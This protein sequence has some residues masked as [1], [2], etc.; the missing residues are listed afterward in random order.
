MRLRI[1][2]FSL[3]LAAGVVAGALILRPLYS[4]KRAPD[5]AMPP[6]VT[7]R[8]LL[9][10]G[11]RQPVRWDGKVSAAGA[12]I[13]AVQG[14]RFGGD[15]STDYKSSWKAST[16]P[17]PA[18]AGAR[19][20]AAQR[21]GAPAQAAQGPIQENGVLI[22]AVI[23]DARASFDIATT[24]GKFSFA[25]QEVGYGEPKTALDGRAS[26]DRVPATVQLTTSDDEQDFPAVAESGD[27]V[28]AAFVE[29]AHSDR[30]KEAR[31]LLSE[32]PKDFDS[33]ARP[34][35]GDQV[36]LMRYSK[37]KRAWTAPEAV[38]EPGQDV[39]RAAVAIDGRKHV[40]VIWSANKNGNYDLFARSQANGKWSSEKRF[41]SDPGSDLN[42]VA[43][44]DAQGRVWIA[45]QAFRN[46]NLGVLAA[47]IDGDRITPEATVS[48]SKMSDW[49]PAIAAA[50]NGE[51]A[52]SWDTYDKGDYDVYVRR[53]RFDKSIRMDQ[54]AAVA[55][56]QN[57]EARSTVA[58]DP[59][60]RL[61]V[62]YEA[63]DVKWG[64]DFG[65]YDTGGV[66][67]YQ[68][69]NLRVKCLEGS[70]VFSTAD[71]VR[72]ALPGGVNLR[73]QA[74]RRRAAQAVAMAAAP[75]MLPDPTLAAGRPMSGT[76]QNLIG[77]APRN[78]FPRLTVDSRG[79]VFLVFRSGLGG[80]SPVGT[81]W[82]ENIAY[83]DGEKWTGPVA[84]P[85]S[86]GLLDVRPAPIAI[87]PGHL[88]MVGVSDHR[89]SAGPGARRLGDS[90]NADLYAADMQVDTPPKPAKLTALAAE[91]VA[92]PQPEARPELAQVT[93][94][95]N[96]RATLSGNQY[97]LMRGEFH[98]HTEMSGDGGNDGPLIDAYRYMIDA[99]YMDW[100]GC[101]D[102]DNGGGREYFWWQQQKLTDAYHLG[103]RY[104]PM[105][106]YER[107]VRYPEGH[108]NVVFPK[109]GIRP[110]PRL[111]K[112]EDDSPP[113]PA[114]DTQMLYRYLKQ[115]GGIVASHT[116]GT[117]MGTDWRDNDP[118]VEPV[119]EIYQGDR[120]NYEMPGAPR[121]NKE[122]D[123][124]GGWRPL[125]FVS[126]ALQ[127]GYR[128][129]FQASSDHVS[130]HMS[131]CNLWVKEP[132]REGIME[133]FHKRRVYGA[134]DNILAD[135]RCG[136]HFMGEEFTLKEPPSISVKLRG[137]QPLAQVHI[138]KDGKYVYTVEP[139]AK[140]VDFVWK[141]NAAER[142]RT[143]YYYVRGQQSDGELVWVS[144]MW[145]RVE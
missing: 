30:S 113:N 16:R 136:D 130:T 22:T 104:V 105:F 107:S 46:G 79:T 3:I 123:S 21:P 117:D 37:S 33:L 58:Y 26:V 91:T 118:L 18:A 87:G 39:A 4:Q 12:D 67:L 20:R 71:D 29:F 108:R 5:Q 23:K 24:Q 28:Y 38:S 2:L 93:T 88:L 74:G 97:R 62:A 98:R 25:A 109:R 96:Y 42:P 78:T 41:T 19:R 140:D 125:G 90:V 7:F 110:L 95:R 121:S 6:A 111:P 127:K 69:H 10:I 132:T 57:Y 27:E 116:S 55:A 89:Q 119:V 31:G 61:W 114:P 48:F 15:D 142:G 64:K 115:F 92:P 80:R 75:R 135:V 40:W 66:S 17:G 138:I 128:L 144:P 73:R 44:A 68:G 52:V 145:I 84:V 45:W 36:K 134:T 83:F 8:V 77:P 1:W 70:N 99:A 112:T 60:N 143:S 47:V 11:D 126:L 49:D 51:V 100:G 65:A 14:W 34:A 13:T 131:Y 81:I 106:S 94:M 124:I 101:C 43:A 122:G 137:S 56:S 63:A 72:D 32:A 76:P 85:H 139:N 129:G 82:A 9:G 59:Q 103:D 120:Q 50:P 141:D 133:A 102:H 53:M 86:D 35:G 54:P